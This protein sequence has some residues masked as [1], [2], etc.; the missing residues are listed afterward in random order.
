MNKRIFYLS[1]LLCVFIPFRAFSVI[2]PE[3]PDEKY[4]LVY[5]PCDFQRLGL[6]DDFGNAL[7]GVWGAHDYNVVQIIGNGVGHSSN[8]KIPDFLR[9]LNTGTFGYICIFTHGNARWLHIEYFTSELSRDWR[10]EQLVHKYGGADGL[11]KSRTPEPEGDWTICVSSEFIQEHLNA[12]L[13]N[14]IIF[15]NACFSVAMEYGSVVQAFLNEGAKCGFGWYLT[16]EGFEHEAP[17]SIFYRMGGSNFSAPP[18]MSDVTQSVLRNK[19]AVDT[20][21]EYSDPNL[22]LWA[23]NT[24]MQKQKKL[25]SGLVF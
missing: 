2:P 25:G 1:I 7:E 3:I 18:G 22:A 14:S 24:E 16:A 11:G 17:I 9:V 23:N 19:S 12:N 8:P 6:M 4:G 15:V 10:Y 5:I 21:V 20:W 13:P